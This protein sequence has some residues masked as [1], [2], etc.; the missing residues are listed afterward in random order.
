MVARV[1]FF[2]GFE[3]VEVSYA[4]GRVG[5]GVG[6]QRRAIGGNACEDPS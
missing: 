5:A 1:R 2:L 3:K 6:V 4:A